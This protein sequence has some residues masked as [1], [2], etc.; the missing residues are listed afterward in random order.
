ME[1]ENM[2]AVEV[3]YALPD[4]QKII[5]VN[6]ELGATALQVIKQSGICDHFPEINSDTAIMGNF[7]QKLSNPA[8]YAVKAGD[9]IEIYCPLIADPKKIRQLRADKL[10]RSKHMQPS[11]QSPEK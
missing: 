4:H 10:R 9:R 8:E 11:P 7:G 2:I 6:V 5:A 1:N 3:A